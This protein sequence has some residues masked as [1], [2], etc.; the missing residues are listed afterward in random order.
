[1]KTIDVEQ[2][3]PED[4]PARALWEFTGRLNLDRFYSPIRSVEGS[5]GQP[6][7]DPRL[8]ISLWL[9]AYSQGC[10]SARKVARMCEHEPGFQWLCGME[11]IN[12]HSLSDFRVEHDEA[13][14][15]L[16][17]QVLGVL[18]AEGLITLERVMHDG[19]RIRA[20]ASGN[21]FG[22]EQTLREHLRLAQ[23]Q[24]DAMGDPRQEPAKNARQGQ[25][26]KRARRERIQRLESA[27]RELETVRAE[28]KRVHKN[29]PRASAADPE[30]RVM[31]RAGGGFEPAYNVQLSTDARAGL[32]VGA[33]VTQSGADAPHLGAAVEQLEK[34]FGK[35][36]GQMVADAGY[37]SN[38]NIVALAGKTELIGP[39][40]TENPARLEGQ[41]KRW[42]ITKDFAKQ[43]FVWNAEQ[44][45]YQCP[46]GKTLSY[47]KCEERPGGVAKIYRA[48]P[49]DC[50]GCPNKKGGC[51]QTA[52]RRIYRFEENSEVTAFRERMSHSE[53]QAVYRQRA[54]IA[55]FPNAWIKEKLGLRQYHVRGLRKATLET[56]WA[57]LTYN[58][59]QWIRLRWRQQVVAAAT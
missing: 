6:T 25:A 30:A 23:E 36:P 59:Q 29:E 21:T 45:C 53:M 55:E 56:L 41:R 10:G 54:Q 38:E 8:M 9:Y 3:I 24:V 44:H 7:W 34:H 22:R 46:A 47:Y 14:R 13:L 12:H 17:T 37:I 15:E 35:A 20:A 50:S 26:Q 58:I 48:K 32:I 43:M 42:G 31:K 2:L 1:M 40:Q 51:P 5:A 27:L 33:A 28:W 39:L 57:V 49:L 18:S 11:P 4:H 16:F 52:Q 19:T